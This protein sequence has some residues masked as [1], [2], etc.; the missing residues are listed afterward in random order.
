MLKIGKNAPEFTLPDQDDRSVSLASLLKRGP[1]IL[2]FYPADFTPG[3]TREACSIRDL[4]GELARAGL[5]VAGVS[6]QTTESHRRFREQYKL[7]FT[8]LS[9]TDKTMIKSYGANGPLGLGVRRVTYLIDPGRVI[10]G[11]VSADFR[12]AEHEEFIRKALAAKS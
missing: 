6:P 4:H 2:Y 3:C 1:L 7:P 12:I 8:L 11:V 5:S 10:R 9:D